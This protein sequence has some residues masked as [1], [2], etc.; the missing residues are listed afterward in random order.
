MSDLVIRGGRVVDPAGGLDAVRDVLL[1]GGKV[2]ELSSGRLEAP[3]ARELD[4]R[5][6]WVLPGFIDLHAHLREPGGEG[7]ETIAS[8]CR[9]AVAGGYTAVVAMPNTQPVIDS[10]LLARH[11]AQRGREVGLCRVYPSGA[12]TRGQEGR[13]LTDMA[14][15]VESGCV[16]LTDDG[17]P[18]MDAGL[19]RR[20]IQWSK[21]LGVPLMLHEE[22]LTLSAGGQ[23]NEGPAAARLGLLPIPSSAEVVMVARD[24]V[25]AEE[26]GGRLH[27]A[28]LSC[29]SSVRLL[30]EGKRRGLQVTA[31]A[32]PHHFTLTD[33]ALEGWDTHARMNPP[34]RSARDVE[35]VCEGLRDGTIDAIAT[36]HAPHA[37]GDK[38]CPFDCAANGIVGLETALPLTLALVHDGRLGLG[39]AVELLSTGPAR[40]FGLPGGTLQ[41]GAPADVTVVDPAREWTIEAARFFSKGRNSPFEGRRVKGQVRATIV[42]GRVVFL[43]GA[44]EEQR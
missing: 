27:F 41:P 19:M 12:I 5:G 34:L 15:L 30:R 2:A 13:A 18:V 1:R 7:K 25:L 38:V 4:A 17:R 8:G 40:A 36:D 11:V 28:H 26:N 6:Q 31:E 21:P 14:E 35:A 16:C 10:G 43:D 3:G 20:A 37:S 24:L 29:A 44:V 9:S 33:E 42:G 32:T 39:R 23:M 22:E